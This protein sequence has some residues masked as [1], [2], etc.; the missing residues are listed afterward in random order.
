M[1]FVGVFEEQNPSRLCHFFGPFHAAFDCIIK[2][3]KPLECFVGGPLE[4]LFGPGV[5]P[6]RRLFTDVDDLSDFL[7]RNIVYLSGRL[8]FVE[9]SVV[10]INEV[11]DLVFFL[12][13]I[14]LVN[15]VPGLSLLHCVSWCQT[16][17]STVE[18]VRRADLTTTK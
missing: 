15:V 18:Q 7:D 4:I 1:L 14:A 10:L 9:M 17:R 3:N 16:C 13:R 8:A 12:I 11:L 6:W 5:R 2:L